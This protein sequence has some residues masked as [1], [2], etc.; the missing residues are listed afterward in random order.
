LAKASAELIARLDIARKALG[1]QA[2][3]YSFASDVWFVI[4]LT[5]L[6]WAVVHLQYD[7]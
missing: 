7:P 1:Q 4:V 2:R 3:K 6:L 5:A